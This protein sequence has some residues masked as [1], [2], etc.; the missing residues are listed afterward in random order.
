MP[1]PPVAPPFLGELETA[2][3]EFFWSE[4]AADVKA[5]HQGIGEPR[6]VTL[7]TTQ[8]T[9]RRLY[10]KGLLGRDKVSHA[11]IYDARISRTEFQ[12][13]VLSEV[14]GLL[15]DGSPASVMSAFV[16]L[17]EQAG[18]DELERLEALVAARLEALT[19]KTGQGE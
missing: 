18:R 16:E 13:R 12:A 6:G 14:A 19:G 5:V 17:T 3:M 7:N 10:D 9:V 4:G 1:S 11:Y 15:G 2:V 8:S